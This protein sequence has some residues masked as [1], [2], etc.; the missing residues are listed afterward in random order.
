MRP[1]LKTLVGVGLCAVVLGACGPPVEKK[2]TLE[3][4]NNQPVLVER[5]AHIDEVQFFQDPD[6]P[7]DA[8][9]SLFEGDVLDKQGEVIGRVFGVRVEGI[10]TS[11]RR[12]E[13][14]DGTVAELGPDRQRRRED[15]RRRVRQRIQERS[16]SGG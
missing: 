2:K 4:I 11:I 12:I 13:W 15:V 3:A 16:D 14:N 7:P 9:F 10:G 8:P 6:V 1:A 5:D